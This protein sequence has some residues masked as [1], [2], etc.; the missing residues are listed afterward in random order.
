[1]KAAICRRYGP[2]ERVTIEDIPAPHPAPAR[3]WSRFR[4]P[5]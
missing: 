3:C 5:A 4:L 2:P 1:M